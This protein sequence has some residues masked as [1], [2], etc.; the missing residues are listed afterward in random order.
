MPSWVWLIDLLLLLLGKHSFPHQVGHEIGADCIKLAMQTWC[1]LV[2]CTPCMLNA[3]HKGL[4][5]MI[6]HSTMA[7][8]SPKSLRTG[9][10]PSFLGIPCLVDR[11]SPGR[12]MVNIGFFAFP[13]LTEAACVASPFYLM[14]FCTVVSV[15]WIP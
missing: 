11:L 5:S 15:P 12:S 1:D 9:Y 8:N 10:P 6:I 2:P 3:P 14:C 4:A 7:S 13:P